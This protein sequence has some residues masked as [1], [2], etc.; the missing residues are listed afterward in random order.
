MA[1]YNRDPSSFD[2]R[3]AYD[4]YLEAVETTVHARARAAG[5]SRRG[6]AVAALSMREGARLVRGFRPSDPRAIDATVFLKVP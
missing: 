2:T 5:E 6:R 1:V 4:D 3:R